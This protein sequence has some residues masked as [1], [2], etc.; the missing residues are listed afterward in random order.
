MTRMLAFGDS[1]AWLGYPQFHQVFELEHNVTTSLHA[2]PGTPASY[3]ALVQ[4][5]ALIKAVDASKAD[6]VY[7]SIGGNDFLEGLPAGHMVEAIHAEMMAA[8]RSMIDRL[9]A[10]RP[11]VHIYHFGYELLDW[12]SDPL[13]KAFGAL[14]LF[15]PRPLC[16]DVANVTCMTRTQATWLQTKFIDEGLAQIYKHDERYHGLNL[17]GT[18]QTA[19][20][21]AGAKV[22]APVWS[23]FSP[24]RYVRTGYTPL[25]CVHL[26]AD[27]YTELYRQMARQ[28]LLVP[29]ARR[30]VPLAP[31]GVLADEKQGPASLREGARQR[32]CLSDPKRQCWVVN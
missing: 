16:M 30:A 19:A 29:P 12:S 28:V 23:Q 6:A 21:V 26:T 22:G 17:Q 31:S 1:W 24:R 14:E 20:G 11:H 8:T 18:L 3:W 27:G 4:P 13:C 32:P 9:L 15:G 10:A 5:D 25:G 2:I 7:L